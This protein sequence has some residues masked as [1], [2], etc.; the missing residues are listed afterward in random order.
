[1]EISMSRDGNLI[2][3]IGN[4]YCT[5]KILRIAVTF[6]VACDSIPLLGQWPIR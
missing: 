5:R 3:N 1:M 2:R 6:L 4:K